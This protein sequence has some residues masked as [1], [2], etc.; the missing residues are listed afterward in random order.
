MERTICIGSVCCS[1][2]GRDKGQYFIVY[3]ILDDQYVLLVDGKQRKVSKPK[4]K[5][6]KH[7][8]VGPE[9]LK[10]LA[11]QIKSNPCLGDDE[12]RKALR[13]YVEARKPNKE[14]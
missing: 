11:D 12:V 6:R 4:R 8:Y 1:R 10:E 3:A 2:A 5:K 14:R 13:G 9:V 7:L